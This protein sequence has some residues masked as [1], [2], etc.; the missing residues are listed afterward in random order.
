MLGPDFFGRLLRS[1]LVATCVAAPLVTHAQS[2]VAAPKYARGDAWT[3]R[4][5][6][7]YGQRRELGRWVA[8]VTEA[9]PDATVITVHSTARADVEERRVQST[10]AI[11]SGR[12]STQVPSGTFSPPLQLYP[13][14][15]APGERWSQATQRSDAT[16][17]GT[18]ALRIE[19]RVIGWEKVR[20]PAGEFDALRIERTLY[21]GDSGRYR[22]Q[23]RRYETEWYAPA[24]KGPVKLQLW[25]QW[26]DPTITRMLQHILTNNRE[27]YE[28]VEYRRVG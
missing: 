22:T 16:V 1:I 9:G 2:P 19:G 15:L 13:A 14:T 28:L 23:T 21:L 20:V 25:E 5:I 6:D 12:I 18:R 11:S 27:L 3:Y 24:V 10:G 4:E 7:G 17:G 8:E 26:S